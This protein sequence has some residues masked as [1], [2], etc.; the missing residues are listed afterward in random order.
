MLLASGP[1]KVPSKK[2]HKPGVAYFVLGL[3]KMSLLEEIFYLFICFRVPG[4]PIQ[5]KN[6]YLTR[7]ES[8]LL[9]F[10]L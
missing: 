7:L 5:E 2:V 10:T 1:S 9:L 8:S 4:K 3:T 6:R